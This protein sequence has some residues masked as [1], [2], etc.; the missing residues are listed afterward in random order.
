MS[1]IKSLLNKLLRKKSN[2][3]K[4]DD[5]TD[6]EWIREEDWGI[7]M[8]QLYSDELRENT[9]YWEVKNETDRERYK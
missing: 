7:K 4:T 5:K 6:E 2:K 3:A 1:K 9:E 8:A